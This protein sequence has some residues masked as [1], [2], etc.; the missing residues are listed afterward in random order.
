MQEDIGKYKENEI[1]YLKQIEDYKN[2]IK[3]LQNDC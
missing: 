2:Q 3:S 1:V